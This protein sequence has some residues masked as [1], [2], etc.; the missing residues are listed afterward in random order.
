MIRAIIEFLIPLCG[1]LFVALSLH[2][3][4]SGEDCWSNC[5]IIILAIGYTLYDIRQRFLKD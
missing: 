5:A 2:G 3:I 1:G 4:F